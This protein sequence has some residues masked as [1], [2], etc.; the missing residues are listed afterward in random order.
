MLR[1]PPHILVTTPESLYLLLTRSAAGRCCAPSRT[2]I[3]DEI[4][5][6]I[7]TRRGAHWRCRSSGCSRRRRAAAAAHR[8]VG[9][10]EADRG[11]RAVPGRRTT[12]AARARSS[13]KGIAGAMDLGGRDS[14]VAARRGDGA[15]GLGGVLRPARRADRRA[16]TTLVFV[17]TRRMAERLARHLSERLGDEAVTAHHG[18]LS[19]ETR[20]DAETRLKTGALQGARRHRVAR[21][22]H[23][24]RPRRSRLPDRFAAP[25]RHAAA[26]RRPIGPHDRRPAEG[27]AVPGV[28]RR[29]DRMRGAA[30]R[31]CAAANST[32]S[33]RTMRRST[34][35]RSRSSPSA[36]AASTREDE[37]FE[38]V[39]RAWP[40]RDLP[41]A[42]FD[43]VVACGRGILHATGPPGGAAAP[44]RGA[45]ARCA[46]AAA[47]AC[48]RS[49][50]AAPFPKSPTT[51]S[52]SSPTRRSSAR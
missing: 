39:R 4:H 46:A 1:T 15:R 21:A 44:R 22:G 35:S 42:R 45:T 52:C 25:D 19:K 51:G 40:Y 28:A 24:H 41:R 8:A 37:L 3:V 16:P 31:R 33:S 23:R 5:A 29:S 30:A 13:T 10:A 9:D 48:W 14:A 20:L 18:S 32:R 38:L 17:N 27:A 11:G 6:V 49:R 47:R 2:V 36:P 50:R 26:A 34:C 43:A 12:R 7:G